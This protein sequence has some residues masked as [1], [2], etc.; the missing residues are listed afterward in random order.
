MAERIDLTVTPRCSGPAEDWALFC[1]LHR[2]VS[3]PYETP[4]VLAFL[5]RVV[6]SLIAYAGEASSTS[7]A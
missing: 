3:G 6:P 2:G 5:Y 7:R 1:N 4:S